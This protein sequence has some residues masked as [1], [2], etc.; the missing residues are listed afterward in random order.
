M[1]YS[2][3]HLQISNHWELSKTKS[4]LL[5]QIAQHNAVTPVKIIF[6]IFYVTPKSQDP[7]TCFTYKDK[8]YI[9]VI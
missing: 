3:H 6:F 2:K 8:H 5:V 4:F 7:K 9:Y 1:R